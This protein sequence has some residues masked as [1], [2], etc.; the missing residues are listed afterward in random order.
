MRCSL[1]GNLLHHRAENCLF[2]IYRL[3]L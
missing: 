1:S 2:E 3:C